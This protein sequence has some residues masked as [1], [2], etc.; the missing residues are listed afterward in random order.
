MEMNTIGKILVI[1]NFIFALVVG[2]FLV[3]DFATRTNWK[4][5]YDNLKRE[6][7]QLK[8]SRDASGAVTQGVT[9]RLKKAELDLKEMEQKLADQQAEAKAGEDTLRFEIADWKLKLTGSSQTL[10]KAKSDVERLKNEVEDRDKTVR[11]REKAIVA[12]EADRNK[13]RAEALAQ[14]GRSKSLQDRNEQLNE[15]VL[16]LSQ[17]L[18]KERSGGGAAGQAVAQTF[19]N[20]NEPNPPGVKVRG[21]IERVDAQ[22]P[23]LVQISLGSDQG[24]NRNNT[25]YAFRFQ[26]QPKYLGMIRI[27][28]VYPGRS[29]GR[30]MTAPG[31]PRNALHEGDEV[32]SELG[33]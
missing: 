1:L 3:I 27:V 15:Q 31:T 24:I 14:E 29:V 26:P 25:L 21:K 16:R 12:L 5:A 22:E 6:M 20:S 28:E 30:L 32:S 9:N 8:A 33:N 19:R 2:G 10:D 7:D 13:Y 4:T 17:D 11:E 23:S 18:A